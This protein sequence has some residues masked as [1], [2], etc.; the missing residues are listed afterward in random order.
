MLRERG[1]GQGGDADDGVD[2][3]DERYSPSTYP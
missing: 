2:A 1:M 3:A